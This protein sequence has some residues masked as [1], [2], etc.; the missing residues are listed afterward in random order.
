L[1]LLVAFSLGDYSTRRVVKPNVVTLI[2]II[3]RLGLSKMLSG[4]C[5]PV[6]IEGHGELPG[7]IIESFS[8][9]TTSLSR[10]N[11]LGSNI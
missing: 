5:S 6:V 3:I 1:T 8:G 4:L 7:G 10:H 9:E 2:V 11:Y